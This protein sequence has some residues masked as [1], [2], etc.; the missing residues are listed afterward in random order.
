MDRFVQRG[1][2]MAESLAAP[3]RSQPPH[4]LADLHTRV[5]GEFLE[6]PGM[7]LTFEQ[8]WRLLGMEPALCERVLTALVI[9]EFL[10]RT[11][12]GAYIRRTG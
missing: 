6:M 8:A 12:D 7:R 5:R 2:A 10:A 3:L 4:G 11:P 9:A 1:L